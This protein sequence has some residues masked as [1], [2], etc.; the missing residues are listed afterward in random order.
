[1]KKHY[2]DT[3]N[4]LYSI[5]KDGMFGEFG[6]QYVSNNIKEDLNKIYFKFKELQ[7]DENF[8]NDLYSLMVDYIGRKSPLYF[9][10]RLTDFYGS[11]KIYLKREDLNHT[12]SHKINNT[13]GQVFLAKKIGKKKIIAE[14]GAGQ[15]G[16]AVATICAFFNIPCEIYM[17]VLDIERQASNVEKIKMLGAKVVSVEDGTKTLK[18]AVDSAFEAYSKDIDNIYYLIGSAVGPAPYPEIVRFFQST[19][20]N[21]IKEQILE[22]ENKM[23]DCVVACA[24]GGSNSIGTFYSFTGEKNV[25]LVLAEA[26]G[27]GENTEKKA[28]SLTKG[29]KEI[30][31]GFKSYVLKD[32]NNDIAEAYSISAG[33]DYPGI[34]PELAHLYNINRL[35]AIAITDK[36]AI[37]A[38]FLLSKLEGI[39]PAIE[40]AHAL[41]VLPKIIN[42]FTKENSII[43][44]I[45]GRG[46]KDCDRLVNKI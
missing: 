31:H 22:K 18:E 4:Y 3:N 29:E 32:K 2:F 12:G 16:V 33:L 42:N 39:I 37:E 10:S 46:D 43:I 19:I 5:D 9:A 6:G 17:G 7:N 23:P 28:C 21:E 25:R 36:E 34:G 26:S 40:S 30:L 35:E 13:L 24:G 1:M 8:L 15:H 11:A 20:G 14:T 27:E 38:F 44:T 41:A 45:S